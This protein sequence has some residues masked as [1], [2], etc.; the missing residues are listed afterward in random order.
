M[1]TAWEFRQM[2]TADLPNVMEIEELCHAFPW[3]AGIFSD[4]LRVGYHCWVIHRAGEIWGYGVMSTGADEAHVLNVSVHPTVRRQ[5]AGEAMMQVFTLQAQE[6]GAHSLFLEVR[7][8]NIGAMRMYE[9]LGYNEIGRRKNYYP[10]P[11]NGREDA[12]LYAK[13]IIT[14]FDP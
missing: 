9:K 6:K 10:A 11:G 13:D 1:T 4:C 5:G 7:P 12:I 14:G 3:T 8:S 2:T